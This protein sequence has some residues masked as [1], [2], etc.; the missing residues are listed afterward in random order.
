MGKNWALPFFWAPVLRYISAP[1]LAILTSFAYPS[2]NRVRNDPLHIY[3]FCVGH[4]VM[5]LVVLG[6]V[7]PRSFDVFIPNARRGEGELPYAPSVLVGEGDMRTTR[8]LEDGFEDYS[9]DQPT[10][11]AARDAGIADGDSSRE[12]RESLDRGRS[13]QVD[14]FSEPKGR[15]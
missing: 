9:H 15:Y 1:I 10:S 4:V 6:L 3:G 12:E 7:V 13:A 14:T 11:K 5:L 2:F 8:G